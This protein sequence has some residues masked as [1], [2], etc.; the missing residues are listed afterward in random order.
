[1][2]HFGYAWFLDHYIILMII[3]TVLG[4][5]PTLPYWWHYP[6]HHHWRWTGR[7]SIVSLV[8]RKYEPFVVHQNLPVVE[9]PNSR[10]REWMVLSLR[11]PRRSL[12][13]SAMELT[14]N[15]P[16]TSQ[17]NRGSAVNSL[18]V[19][20]RFLSKVKTLNLSGRFLLRGIEDGS[21]FSYPSPPRS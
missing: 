1:M 4:I 13:Q 17:A 21:I 11:K 9:R 7:V 6:S 19:V 16:K 2:G 15:V 18:C 20:N 14:C 3:L 10:I 12:A 8:S 5:K